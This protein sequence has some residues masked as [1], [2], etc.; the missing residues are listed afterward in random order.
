MA[1][2]ARS[3]P[4]DFLCNNV[5]IPESS[6]LVVN[7]RPDCQ[8]LGFE[9]HSEN[10]YFLVTT[11]EEFLDTFTRQ[12][13]RIGDRPPFSIV[14]YVM[15]GEPRLFDVYVSRNNKIDFS[16]VDW[17]TRLAAARALYPALEPVRLTPSGP[18]PLVGSYRAM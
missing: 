7:P 4:V 6:V 17:V 13:E 18:V 11:D 15:C 2:R 9:P 3:G 16:T 12:I 14:Q 8:C 5:P 1:L 10:S